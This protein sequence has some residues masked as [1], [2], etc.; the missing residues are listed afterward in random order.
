M[1]LLLRSAK[2][3]NACCSCRQFGVLIF[4]HKCRNNTRHVPPQ[5]SLSLNR[6]NASHTGVAKGCRVTLGEEILFLERSIMENNTPVNVHVVRFWPVWQKRKQH[7]PHH[8]ETLKYLIQDQNRVKEGV[9]ELCEKALACAKNELHPLLQHAD[10]DRLDQRADF[11]Q[12]FRK[13]IEIE[14]AQK[15][16]LWVPCTKIVYRFDTTYSSRVE[17]WDNII[18]LLLV[19]PQILP[20]LNNFGKKFDYEMVQHLTALGWTRFQYSKTVVEILQVTLNE[21][22]HGVSYGGMFFSANSVPAQIWPPL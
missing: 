9:K 11:L 2:R 3:K 20:S 10:L 19:V 4:P 6:Q 7:D 18:H 15:I 14:M 8:E 16:T 1:K 22:H 5:N 21:I 17:K 13:A 12:A